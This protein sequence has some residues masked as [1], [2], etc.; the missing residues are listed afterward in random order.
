MRY[1]SAVL[2]TIHYALG[3]LFLPE[4]NFLY[5][6]QVS[7]I[8]SK[9]EIVNGKTDFF[10]FVEENFL[11]LENKLCIENEIDGEDDEE[12]EPFEK[13]EQQI[14][15]DTISVNINPAF[16]LSTVGIDIELQILNCKKNA[17][18]IIKKY[19]TELIPI[20][21]PPKYIFS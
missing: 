8:Y 2:L 17:F 12:D 21:H 16:P 14:P 10:T 3:T 13:E 5:L 1:F 18:Y 15:F 11:E 9:Y 19:S 7:D 6:L 20:F 4:G